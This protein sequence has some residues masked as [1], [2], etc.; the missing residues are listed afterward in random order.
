MDRE[1]R[2][3]LGPDVIQETSEKLLIVQERLRAAQSRSKS[4][5]DTR[6]TPLEFAVGDFVYLKVSPRKGVRRFGVKGKLAPRFVGPFQIA[7]RVGSVAYRI[8]L[9]PR[10]Q[11]IHDV[12]HVSLLRK[13]PPGAPQNVIWTDVQ[14]RSDASYEERPYRI[15]DRDVRKLRNREVPVVKVQWDHHSEEEATWELESVMRQ[16]HPHLF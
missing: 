15:L 3:L 14:L 11:H 4:Y 8:H 12:F 1:D 10:L 2:V 13:S 16:A 7:Q 5:A 6:R 9:P